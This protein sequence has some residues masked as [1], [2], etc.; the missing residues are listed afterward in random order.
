MTIK[1][2]G[3]LNFG[4]TTEL[5]V[6]LIKEM[7]IKYLLIFYRGCCWHCGSC[8][9]DGIIVLLIIISACKMKKKASKCL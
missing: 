1:Y 3:A 9:G 8:T 6:S 4:L 2:I 5:G 7:T